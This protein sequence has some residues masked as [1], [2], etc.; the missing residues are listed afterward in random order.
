MV[1]VMSELDW[2]EES[3]RSWRDVR[4]SDV[5]CNFNAGSGALGWCRG[6]GWGLP[7]RRT[8]LLWPGER[9]PEPGL[10]DGPR[11]RGV[12]LWRGVQDTAG[13]LLRP[14]PGLSRYE[15]ALASV[16]RSYTWPV[17]LN[18]KRYHRIK[19]TS[20]EIQMDSNISEFLLKWRCK[21]SIVCVLELEYF[22]VYWWRVE[23]DR[24]LYKAKSVKATS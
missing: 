11:A 24:Y 5:N 23:Q 20:F 4:V 12:L 7:R 10:E 15:D 2:V 6:R 13:L 14:P 1:G 8:L 22:G 9:V 3:Q 19:T 18:F 17:H 16:K 21:Q